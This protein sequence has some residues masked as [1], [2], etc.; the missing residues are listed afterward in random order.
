[1]ECQLEYGK[2][3]TGDW[4]LTVGVILLLP[5]VSGLSWGNGSDCGVGLRGGLLAQGG[6][7]QG[8]YEGVIVG[9]SRLSEGVSP[10]RGG[11]K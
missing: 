10:E 8:G 2:R 6:L 5:L 11:N 7:A 4:R 3:P 9:G 1:M